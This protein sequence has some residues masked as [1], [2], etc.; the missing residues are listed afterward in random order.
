MQD[1]SR[2]LGTVRVVEVAVPRDCTDGFLIA[3]WGRPES[4]LD[5][6][7]RAATSGFARMDDAREAAAVARLEADLRSGAWE[8]KHGHLRARSELDVGL[9][10]VVAE[11]G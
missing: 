9:R 3:Y 6:A 2:A 7:A 4:L 1:L 8:R 11:L 10:L 5:P